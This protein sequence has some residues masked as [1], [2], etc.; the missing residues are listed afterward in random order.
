MRRIEN[1]EASSV[2]SKSKR[3]GNPDESIAEANSEFQDNLDEQED[4][5]FLESADEEEA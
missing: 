1:G 4:E 2:N 3:L 5:V